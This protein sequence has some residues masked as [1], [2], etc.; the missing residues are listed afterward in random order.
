V[1]G[2]GGRAQL[3]VSRPMKLCDILTLERILPE[4]RS[5]TKRDALD[6]LA[7]LMAGSDELLR[8]Q[9]RRVLADRER[10]ASTAIGD[11]VAIPHGKLEPQR[12]L[13]MGLG[14]SS[15]GLPFESVD[16]QPTR[17]FFV[18]L[19]AENETGLHLK[20][21]ARISRL[22]KEPELRSRLLQAT[23]AEQMYDVLCSEDAKFQ[24][25]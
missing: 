3:G 22:C 6:E 2:G 15:A 4:M 1:N 11:G 23:S 25:P 18:L 7:A 24:G 12:S 8:E 9:V 20:A 10:L 16:G 14:R 13:S 21:L 19:A 17:L 5:R